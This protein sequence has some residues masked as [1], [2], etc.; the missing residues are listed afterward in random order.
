MGD[1]VGDADCEWGDEEGLGADEPGDARADEGMLEFDLFADEA[2]FVEV[3]GAGSVGGIWG[4][5]G[6]GISLARF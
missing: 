6:H 5:Y 2:D 1:L 4:G 3:V